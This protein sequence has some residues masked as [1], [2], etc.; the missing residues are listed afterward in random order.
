MLWLKRILFSSVGCKLVVA[1]TGLGLVGFLVAHLAGNFLVFVGPEAINDYARQLR[2]FPLILW[3]LRLGL[4]SIFFIHIAFTIRLTRLNK[5]SNP[6]KYAVPSRELSSFA[7]RSMILSGLTVLSF[8][9]YHLAHLT[10]RLTNPLFEQ[11]GEYDVYAMLL[12]SFQNP[13]IVCFYILSVCLLMVHLSHGI[14]S[15]FQTFGIKHL[16][17]NKIVENSS[18]ALSIFLALGFSSIPIRIC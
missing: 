6:Q 15:S 10:F 3:I 2:K 1:L 17:Y 7:S 12:I 8:V 16:K 13:I 18:I 5:I 14:S 11:L 9:L 4:I